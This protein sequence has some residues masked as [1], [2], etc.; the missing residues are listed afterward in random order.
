MHLNSRGFEKK[1]KG[2]HTWV[3][4]EGLELTGHVRGLRGDAHVRRRREVHG[5]SVRGSLAGRGNGKRTHR[6]SARRGAEQCGGT[7]EHHDDE[8]RI[9]G[10]R[11]V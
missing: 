1:D 4:V 10:R 5:R 11:S 7:G 6:D 9:D 3:A 2:V 8:D